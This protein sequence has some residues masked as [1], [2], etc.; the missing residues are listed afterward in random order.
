LSDMGLLPSNV[1]RRVPLSLKKLRRELCPNE[2]KSDKP[3]R[4][5]LEPTPGG[6]R[7]VEAEPAGEGLRIYT[8]NDILT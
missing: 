2:G 7:L 3:V 8:K 6:A 4:A 1:S 5:A